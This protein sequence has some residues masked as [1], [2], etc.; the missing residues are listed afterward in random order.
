MLLNAGRQL[1]T[2]HVVSILSQSGSRLLNLLQV[3]D[4]VTV[5]ICA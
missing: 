4:E 3:V 5:D 1:L 2:F